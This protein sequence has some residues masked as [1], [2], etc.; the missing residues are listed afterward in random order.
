MRP[1]NWPAPLANSSNRY[2]SFWKNVAWNPPIINLN[3]HY[4]SRY[5]GENEA[6]EPKVISKIKPLIWG[7]YLRITSYTP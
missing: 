2:G 3:A 6:M 5:C 1:A 7:G 4:G